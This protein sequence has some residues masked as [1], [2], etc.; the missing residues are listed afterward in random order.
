LESL[1]ASLGVLLST[2]WV[3][4]SNHPVVGQETEECVK[5]KVI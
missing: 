5:N 1:F 4:Y 3:L 2:K